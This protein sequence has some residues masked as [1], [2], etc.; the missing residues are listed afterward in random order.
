M[1]ETRAYVRAF[2][3]VDPDPGRLLCQLNSHMV[4]EIDG[5]FV[6]MVVALIAANGRQLQYASAGHPAYLA[7][8]QGVTELAAG[9]PPLGV[10]AE[11]VYESSAPIALEPKDLLFLPTDGLFEA[12]SPDGEQFGVERS[13]AAIRNHS[14][15]SPSESVNTVYDQVRQFSVDRLLD[16]VTMV[17]VRVLEETVPLSWTQTRAS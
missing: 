9:G 12:T 8:G 15:I 16:D 10:M 4:N 1:A 13:L 6:T 11:S 5:Y 7:H 3:E 17:V 14:D 2:A